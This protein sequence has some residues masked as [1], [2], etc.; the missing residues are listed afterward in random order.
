V[1]NEKYSTVQWNAETQENA[2]REGVFI[3]SQ[4]RLNYLYNEM[5]KKKK[6][7]KKEKKKKEKK[8]EKEKKKKKEKEEEEEEKEEEEE[9]KEK[10]EAKERY[11]VVNSDYNAK[12]VPRFM[13]LALYSPKTLWCKGPLLGNN[14]VNTF[15]WEPTEQ[16]NNRTRTC[17][18]HASTIEWLCFQCGRR[19]DR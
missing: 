10:E 7:E 8:K 5:K 9:E 17:G 18:K 11:E 19:S 1:S 12:V 15:P 6:K 14:S 3:L 13:Q 4:N 16:W 2:E